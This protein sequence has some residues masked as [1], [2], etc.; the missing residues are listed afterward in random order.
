MYRLARNFA[1]PAAALALAAAQAT[2]SDCHAARRLSRSDDTAIARAAQLAAREHVKQFTRHDDD[3]AAGSYDV[4]E[5]FARDTCT[6]AVTR[7]DAKPMP[8]NRTNRAAEASVEVLS[9]IERDSTGE[10]TKFAVLVRRPMAAQVETLSWRPS[11]DDSPL[12]AERS[13]GRGLSATRRASILR[14]AE[15]EGETGVLAVA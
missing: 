9:V 8:A 4:L 1:R 15:D 7:L 2:S 5:V 11:C 3:D 10:A 12:M 14:N 6:G 13:A